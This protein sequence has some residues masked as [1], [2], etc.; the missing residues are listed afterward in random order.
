MPEL[1][2]IYDNCDLMA[3]GSLIPDWQ[4]ARR[5]DARTLEGRFVRM[6]K[7][8]PARHGDGLYAA[9]HGPDSDAKLYD[10]LPWGPFSSRIDFDT[11]LSAHTAKP[12]PWVYCVVDQRTGA[13]L[14]NIGLL[15]I[16][17]THGRIAIGGVMFGACM[18][19]TPKGTEAFYLLAKEAFELGNRRLEWRCNSENA[20]SRRAAERFGYTFEGVFRQQMVLKGINRNTAHLSILHTEW[21]A[22]REAFERWLA[23]EN[24][25]EAGQQIKSLESFRVSPSARSAE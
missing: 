22:V 24:F 13:V 16:A 12:D 20:R 18:Q 23:L 7:L 14:G 1:D 2:S 17:P 4:P 21:P 10:Y 6:E 25:D 11:W 19:R 5:P 15:G 9:L 3:A 8:E